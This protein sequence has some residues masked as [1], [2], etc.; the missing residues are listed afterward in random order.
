VQ[1]VEVKFYVCNIVTRKTYNVHSVLCTFCYYMLPLRSSYCPLLY[2]LSNPHYVFPFCSRLVLMFVESVLQP[3]TTWNTKL[4][5]LR[6]HPLTQCYLQCAPPITFF[7]S[8]PSYYLFTVFCQ[9]FFIIALTLSTSSPRIILPFASYL[10][11][12]LED[13]QNYP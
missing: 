11:Y 8:A 6:L 7:K 9:H 2:V 13:D 1:Q 10:V 12:I 3:S 4:R 5:I